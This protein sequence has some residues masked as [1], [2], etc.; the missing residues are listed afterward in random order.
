M[1]LNALII[2]MDIKED[3]SLLRMAICC[4]MDSFQVKNKEPIAIHKMDII[5]NKCSLIYF[6]KMLACVFQ[7]MISIV[8]M[9]KDLFVIHLQE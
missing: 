4:I 5:V 6:N 3:G 7:I 9:T 2:V 1:E 8:F